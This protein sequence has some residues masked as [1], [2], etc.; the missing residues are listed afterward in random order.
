MLSSSKH[1]AP[2][3]TLVP[4]AS[5]RAHNTLAVSAT[6]DYF[7]AVQDTESLMHT[8]QWY[9]QEN[10]DRSQS[11]PLLLLGGGSNLVLSGDF[12]GLALKLQLLGRDVIDEDDQH[13]WL[14]VGSGENWHELVCYCMN[15][16]W[17]GLENL[18]LIPG[19]VG[20]APVQNIGAYGVEL[21]DLFS[22]LSA[23]EISSGVT[24][25][26]D[27]D[28]CRFGYRDSIFKQQFKDKYIITSVTLKLR[29]EAVLKIDYP[30]LQKRF[31][32]RPQGSI[33]P[34]EV[35]DAVCEI[36]SSKLPDPAQI[37]NVGSFF[38]NPVVS[39]E[40]FERLQENF[41]GIVGFVQEQNQVKLAAGWLI[42]QAGWRGRAMGTAQVHSEQALVLTN[43]GQGT[44]P[45]VL[46]L[47]QAIVDDVETRYGVRLQMEPRVY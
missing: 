8:L 14:K 40:E 10:K 29:K 31:I 43:P 20:A 45:E 30:V 12:H 32:D 34:S 6:A 47:A 17:W 26:F 16:H 37:P 38:K 18:A 42:D 35:F 11:M 3:A 28:A 44:G 36:R 7:I 4:G 41:E 21:Q 15:F 9:K 13:V 2:P 39:A 46:Q 1:V 23:V 24:I 27:R 33:A 25:N 5:L 19:N 22:E